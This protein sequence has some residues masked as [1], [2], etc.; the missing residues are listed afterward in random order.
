MKEKNEKSSLSLVFFSVFGGLLSSSCCILQLLLNIVSFGCAGFAILDGLRSYFI[1]FTFCPLIGIF[2]FAKS[3]ENRTN[4]MYSLLIAL[5]ITF[6]K[7]GVQYFNEK[8]GDENKTC[9]L[10]QIEEV[11]C[12]GCAA[13]VHTLVSSFFETKPFLSLSVKREENDRAKIYIDCEQKKNHWKG[14]KTLIVELFERQWLS[15]IYLLI[16]KRKRKQKKEEKDLIFFFHF[17]F[18]QKKMDV[19]E[20]LGS[21]SYPPNLAMAVFVSGIATFILLFFVTA[22]FGKHEKNTSSLWGK[23]K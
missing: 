14:R 10:L 7:E 11:H 3:K 17:F 1:F 12:D 5:L 16:P 8:N 2:L 19:F 23:K 15:T 9:F 6:S 21:L 4:A 18:F 20:I 22:P 13:N